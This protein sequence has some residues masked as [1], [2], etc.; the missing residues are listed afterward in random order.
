MDILCSTDSIILLRAHD[1]GG[2]WSGPGVTGNIFN[3]AISGPG[4]HIISYNI[5]DKNGC[6]DFDQMTITVATP[7][8]T[9]TPVD[10]L[11]VN[12]PIITLK[13]HDSGGIWSGMGVTGNTFDPMIAG[14][15]DH[16]IRYSILNTDCKDSDTATI[17]VEPIPD[18]NIN[19]IGILY[20]NSPSI[21]LNATPTGGIFSGEGVTGNIFSP[22]E[23]GIG[24]H[25]VK[26]ET[27]PDR[28]GC[29]ATDTIH[30]KVLKPPPT[31]SD[32]E[33][34]TVGCTPLTVQFINKSFYADSYIWDFGDKQYSAEENPFHTYYIPGNYIVKLI[35]YNSSGQS[36]HNEIITVYQNPSAI[37]NAYPTNVVNNEQIVV[38]YNYSYYDSSYLWRFGD[39]QI[40]TEENPFHKYKNPGSY[41]V[42][43][44]VISKDGCN[45]SAVLET[46]II[47]EWKTGSVKF[48]NVFKWNGTGP[49]GG[50]WKEGVYPEMDDVFRPFFENVIEYKLQVFNR[51][52]VLIYESHDLHK[53]W[54]GYFGDG[55]LAVQG[56]YVWKVTGRYADGKYFDM[57]GD[58]TFL[59]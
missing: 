17:T 3:P 44:T 36:V 10:T 13:A 32:F 4:N 15:G 51:W 50:Q 29:M 20:T 49:T 1:P 24:T 35:A 19:S 54:D 18:I 33:P 31:I 59:H 41:K 22:G 58:V 21:T 42:S 25:I 52:G 9:I 43:L 8:A 45:D 23:A 14:I 40:S 6:S 38:F 7:D 46:P 11:C 28:Y 26:Y 39:G 56:V 12:S 5:T 53:G 34:D 27:I 30:I 55:N 37:L 48:P 16:I 47:V 2:I 57:V